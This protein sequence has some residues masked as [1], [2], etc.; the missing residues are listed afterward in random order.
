VLS[1]HSSSPD[2]DVIKVLL[3]LN[4]RTWTG[5]NRPHTVASVQD[6]ENLAAARLAAGAHAN[7]IDADDLAVRLVVQSHR[8]SGL[9]TVYTDLLDFAGNEIYMRAEPSLAGHPYG[10]VLDAYEHGSPIGLRRADGTIQVNP[11]MHE[12]V[13]EGDQIILIAEDD[14][15]IKPATAQASVVD[16]ALVAKPG[17]RPEAD[18][19]LLVGWNSRVPRTIDLLDRLAQPGSVV[20]IA[21]PDAP[22]AELAHNLVNLI[23]G[24]KA[25]ESTNRASL[26][27]L[28][29]GSY[30]HIIVVPD[31]GLEAERAD[32]R[33]LV[34][35]LHLRD[36]E[37]RIGG[38]FSIVT[39]MND[40]RN[41]EIAQI[42]KADDFIVSTKMISLLM[43]Q[44]AENKHLHGVFTEL[45]DPDG[46]E[47]YLKPAPD[48]LVAGQRANFATVIE[49]ARQRGESAIGYRI[50]QYSD[51]APDFGVVMNP[52]KSAPLTLSAL[53]S[54][55]VVAED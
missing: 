21:T 41:R 38:D 3:L 55:I 2:I 48:Y 42:T 4:H 33:T 50:K 7:V 19:T 20:D 24:H 32:D 11:P 40:D 16:S 27:A 13:R 34:T 28:D 1:P 22:P 6:T 47:I 53:D 12:P 14:F 51:R 45:F 30:D 25:C 44:L 31:D 17:T 15:L 8:Q 46:C 35:L 9:S 37:E 49:S 52:S 23:V 43:I 10:K 29:L 39:E 26:E 54:V 5:A 36:L 18:R